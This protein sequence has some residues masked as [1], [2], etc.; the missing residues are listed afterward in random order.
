MIA[1]TEVSIHNQVGVGIVCDEAT[2]QRLIALRERIQAPLPQLS[3]PVATL[4][5]P[6]T[7]LQANCDAENII[8]SPSQALAPEK[9]PVLAE[10]E[11]IGKAE[12]WK[13]GKGL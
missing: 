7:Q 11:S 10:M 6:Q 13:H 8:V 2:R 1:K 4:P 3:A 9:D 5:A 12:S